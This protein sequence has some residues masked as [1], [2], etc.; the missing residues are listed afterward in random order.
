MNC[1]EVTEY[2][3][4]QLDGDLNG[5]ETEIL[6][7]HT[8]HCPECAAMMER[9]QLLNDG[10]E[11]L[12]KVTPSY[13]LVDAILPRLAELDL[14]GEAAKEE[15]AMAEPAKVYRFDEAVQRSASKRRWTNRYSISAIAAVAAVVIVFF[16]FN[17]NLNHQSFD[18][19]DDATVADSSASA[20]T[21]MNSSNTS[22]DTSTAD[23]S[24][25]MTE[26]TADSGDAA[27]TDAAS[28]NTAKS[29]SAEKRSG[30]Q[31][32]RNV[33]PNGETMPPLT[34]SAKNDSA[35]TANAAAPNMEQSGSSDTAA[36]DSDSKSNANSQA[37]SITSTSDSSSIAADNSAADSRG[38]DK[39]A[40]NNQAVA[41][42]S[43]DGKKLDNNFVANTV[44]A[45]PISPDHLYQAFIVEDHVEIYTV[46]DSVLVFQGTKHAGIAN[47][48]WSPDS[49]ELT[50]ETTGPDGAK[51]MF[52][53]EVKSAAEQEQ[54]SKN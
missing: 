15:D 46:Q 2:M 54:S 48:K 47:L 53:V 21:D 40:N 11:N 6:I 17:N 42:S 7:T 33:D 35:P 43:N 24:T 52:A 41:G 32:P 4:R 20:S 19:S 16:L 44:I 1:Q 5:E 36:A 34:L 10:L 23:Q 45:S 13:S 25:M 14:H 31:E 22:A 8:R 9:L 30:G 50:Y 29:S 26:S 49:K 28:N 38:S 39:A 37:N 3:Q 12:P 18:A 51:K 27:A